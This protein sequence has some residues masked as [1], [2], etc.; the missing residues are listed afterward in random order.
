[1]YNP[2]L[3]IGGIAFIGYI[4]LGSGGKRR[5]KGV[6][7]PINQR[8]KPSQYAGFFG[9]GS[10]KLEEDIP[11]AGF[12]G[13]GSSKLEEP[14]LPGRYSN[15][16][17]SAGFLSVSAPIQEDLYGPNRYIPWEQRG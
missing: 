16:R 3:V 13:A 4:A 14:V 11:Y 17:P 5:A 10:S 7:V 12:F 15:A 6:Y 8:L 9:A 2:L 1:M